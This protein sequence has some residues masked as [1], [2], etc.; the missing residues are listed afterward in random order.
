M[1]L[2]R[3]GKMLTTTGSDTRMYSPRSESNGYQDDDD[4]KYGVG[5]KKKWIR[6]VM[7]SNPR[8][9]RKR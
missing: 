2:L 1:D 6:F 8:K 4:Y 7:K 9:R 5:P 3:G